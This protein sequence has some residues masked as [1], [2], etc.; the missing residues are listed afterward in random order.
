MS[1]GASGGVVKTL[2]LL[3][4]RRSRQYQFSRGGESAHFV[5]LLEPNLLSPNSQ[6]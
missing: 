2:G 4:F 6:A 5:L 1:V 3:V